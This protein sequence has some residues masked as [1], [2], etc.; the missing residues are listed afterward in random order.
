MASMYP[1]NLGG[2]PQFFG[3][4]GSG[5]FPG[6]INANGLPEFGGSIDR[7]SFPFF[8]GPAGQLSGQHNGI[9]KSSSFERLPLSSFVKYQA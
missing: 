3:I 1:Q 5:V 9:P 8:L 6:G 7:A 4:M 2:V